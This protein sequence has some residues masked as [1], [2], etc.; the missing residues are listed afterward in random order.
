MNYLP[1][2][3]NAECNDMSAVTV[4]KKAALKGMLS[5]VQLL[6]DRG[7][8]VDVGHPLHMWSES[9]F[10][11]GFTLYPDHIRAGKHG[12]EIIDRALAEIN[13]NLE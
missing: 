6:L 5:T 2:V 8:R 12:E 11:P 7:S 4:L 1:D 3:P 10:R 13:F 9:A